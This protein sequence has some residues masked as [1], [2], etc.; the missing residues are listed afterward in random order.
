MKSIQDYLFNEFEIKY[1][2]ILNKNTLNTVQSST[3]LLMF[4]NNIIMIIIVIIMII[5]I[6]Y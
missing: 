4:N 2:H 6:I 5:I 3:T 1:N